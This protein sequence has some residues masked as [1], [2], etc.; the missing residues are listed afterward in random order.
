MQAAVF[1]NRTHEADEW[2]FWVLLIKLDLWEQA[3]S[4]GDFI[5]EHLSVPS[6]DMF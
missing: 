4:R 6:T 5:W 2:G 1:V 3:P